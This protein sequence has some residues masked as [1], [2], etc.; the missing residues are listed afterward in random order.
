VIGR[1]ELPFLDPAGKTAVEVGTLKLDSYC[2][3]EGIR[4]DL[5]KIDV[6]GAE[7]MVLRGAAEVL[8]RYRPVL[9][10]ST[11]PYWFPPGESADRLFG[12]LADFGYQTRDSHVIHFE[13]YK[14]GDYLMTA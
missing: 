12:F 7:G 14:I 4:P 11:H 3:A 2:D 9:V 8:K 6:E 13:G 5:I 1:P 10:F